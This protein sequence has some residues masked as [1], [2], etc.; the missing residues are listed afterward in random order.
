MI[1]CSTEAAVLTSDEKARLNQLPDAAF[2]VD[3]EVECLLGDG[4][5]GTHVGL[6]QSQDHAFD[7]QTH[8]WLQ[9]ADEGGQEWTH[10]SLCSAER[11]DE[12]CLLPVAHAL[13]HHWG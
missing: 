4:H 10:Q 11:G 12:V 7:D 1:Y 8:W 9:W 6:A 3:L 13:E 2:E 5:A